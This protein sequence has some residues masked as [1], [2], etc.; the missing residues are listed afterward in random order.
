MN[1][2]CGFWGTLAKIHSADYRQQVLQFQIP[3][4]YGLP[5]IRIL[6][7]VNNDARQT[8]PASKMLICIG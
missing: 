7:M 2:L 1:K 8:F 3:Y 5:S 4:N 6:T